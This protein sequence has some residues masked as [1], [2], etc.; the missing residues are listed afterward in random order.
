MNVI[1]FIYKK[2]IFSEKFCNEI[3]DEIKNKNWQK[4]TWYNPVTNLHH[5]EDDKE[6]DIL[7]SSFSQQEKFIPFIIEVTKEYN[8]K[9]LKK[10]NQETISL[11]QKLTN[12]RFNRYSEGTIMKEHY[13]HIH[14]IFDGQDKGIP[15][16]S[17][18]GNLNENYTG[19]DL[20]ICGKSMN[21]KTGDI[22]IFPS[23]FLYPHKVTEVQ[24]GV[25]Y[26][27]VTWGF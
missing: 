20:V 8:K 10:K 5:S 9:F 25:R 13:D 15:I 24:K 21:L 6:L 2:K 19:G 4:H 22:C 12:I 16:L 1:D 14:A 3:V 7:P 17:Y 11:I 18:V 26:S 27:F 23:C